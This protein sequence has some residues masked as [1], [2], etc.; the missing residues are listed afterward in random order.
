MNSF[1]AIYRFDYP[2]FL[3]KSAVVTALAF[4]SFI[5][6]RETILWPSPS[7]TEAHPC[8]MKRPGSKSSPCIASRI[9]NAVLSNLQ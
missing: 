8:P 5:A 9:S 2:L 6:I 4:S 3:I 7:A 1:H